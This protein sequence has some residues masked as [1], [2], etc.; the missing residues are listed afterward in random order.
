MPAPIEGDRSAALEFAPLPQVDGT[1]NLDLRLRV[2]GRGWRGCRGL[3][4]P[5]RYVPACFL[6]SQ[7]ERLCAARARQGAGLTHPREPATERVKS[8][9]VPLR[10]TLP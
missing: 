10:T 8:C 6:R 9:S 7:R 3:G 2:G 5:S 1:F 4:G